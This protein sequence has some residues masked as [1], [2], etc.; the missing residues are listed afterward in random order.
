MFISIQV[1][2]RQ[3]AYSPNCFVAT[4]T[5][6]LHRFAGRCR[7]CLLLDL[8]ETGGT[9]DQE[10]PLA[11]NCLT[12][13]PFKPGFQVPGVC[14]VGGRGGKETADWAN[15]PQDFVLPLPVLRLCSQ[16]THCFPEPVMCSACGPLR[17]LNFLL[18]I[19][20]KKHH[21]WST[22]LISNCD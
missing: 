21:Y 14:E 3:A 20:G 22:I 17:D 4:L 19:P 2:N 18:Q 11:L 15:R 16:H 13:P 9:Q 7:I 6:P 1:Q 12:C 10:H 5:R 8:Q